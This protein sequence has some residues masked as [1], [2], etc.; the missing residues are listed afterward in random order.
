MQNPD[1]GSLVDPPRGGDRDRFLVDLRRECDEHEDAATARF[2]N[3]GEQL[4]A[5]L[6]GGPK[7]EVGG[8]Y[9]TE[10]LAVVRAGILSAREGGRVEVAEV[11]KND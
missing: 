4:E 7:P 2:I 9:A 11:L 5:W 1:I 3:N 6:R 8:E 10:S